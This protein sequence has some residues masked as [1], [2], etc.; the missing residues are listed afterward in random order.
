[1]EGSTPPVCGAANAEISH[2]TPDKL[3][4]PINSEERNKTEFEN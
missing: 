1:V 3:C 2:P 4:P